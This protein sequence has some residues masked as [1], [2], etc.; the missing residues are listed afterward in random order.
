VTL[1]TFLSSDGEPVRTQTKKGCYPEYYKLFK[2]NER[3]GSGKCLEPIGAYNLMDT[4]MPLL[5][6]LQK[7]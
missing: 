7:L 2:G 1:E 6:Y 3:D 4:L 5:A